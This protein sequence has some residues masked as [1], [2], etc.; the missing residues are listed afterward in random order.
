M[1]DVPGSWLTVSH[2]SG[3]TLINMINGVRQQKARVEGPEQT[4]QFTQLA[5]VHAPWYHQEETRDPS[6]VGCQAAFVGKLDAGNFHMIL[7]SRPWLYACEP[8]LVPIQALANMSH[9]P[10]TRVLAV[11]AVPQQSSPLMSSAITS[12]ARRWS[13]VWR[14]AQPR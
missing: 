11:W 3:P 2:I 13:T 4:E 5:A 1:L 8:V 7:K 14:R 10:A 6:R 9:D 12:I